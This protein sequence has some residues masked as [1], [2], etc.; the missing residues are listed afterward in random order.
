MDLGIVESGYSVIWDIYCHYISL[1][2]YFLFCFCFQKLIIDF[3]SV[4]PWICFPG[5]KVT[6]RFFGLLKMSWRPELAL[7]IA[8]DSFDI[9]QCLLFSNVYII[10][11]NLPYLILFDRQTDQQT[12]LQRKANTEAPTQSLKVWAKGFE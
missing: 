4:S 5:L 11:L 12:N 8:V 7:K 10:S 3:N 2:I 6:L 1:E 9:N